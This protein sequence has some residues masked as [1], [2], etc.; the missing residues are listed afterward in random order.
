MGN[1][2]Q[3]AVQPAPP[4]AIALAARAFGDDYPEACNRRR[5]RLACVLLFAATIVYVPWMWRSLNPALPWLAW[6]FAAANTFSMLSWWVTAL[7]AWSREVP[8]PRPAP[9]GAEPTVAVLIP[10]CGEPIPMVLR[11]VTSVLEQD[12]PRD[13][14]L[15]VVSDDGHDP[16]LR[17]ALAG[18][19]VTYHEPPDRWAPGRDGAAK[20]GNLN[21]AMAWLAEAH[22]DVQFI[23]TRDADDDLGTMRFLRLVVGQL[24]ADDRLA[25]VQS[26]KEAEVSPGDPFNNRDS[27]F[28]RGQMLAR[29]AANAVFPCGSGVVWRRSALE[30]IG[31]FPTWN[32]VEDLQSGVE[33]LRR[34]WR[35]LYLPI[36][37]AVGQHS[38]EDVP[39]VYK[40]R[41]TWA[42]DTVRL[43]VWGDLRGLRLRQ[44]L[45]FVELLLFYLHAFTTVV[46]VPAVA[47]TLLGMLPIVDRPLP[48]FAHVVPMAVANELLLLAL[49]QPYNDRRG[50]QRGQFRA[51]WRIRAMWVGM[52]PVFMVACV[53]AV[54]GGPRRKP[55]YKV[56]RKVH[57]V[58]WHWREI[59]PQSAALV[60]IATV[61][62]CALVWRTLPDAAALFGGLYWGGFNVALF[63]TFVTRS[64]H[65]V[66]RVVPAVAVADGRAAS[67]EEPLPVAVPSAVGSSTVGLSTVGLAEIVAAGERAGTAALLQAIR[68]EAGETAAG[69]PAVHARVAPDDV[70]SPSEGVAPVPA[71]GPTDGEHHRA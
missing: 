13:R 57:D 5:I 4:G 35:G 34:G 29:N 70:A 47:C 2:E 24:L 10:T 11:T 15:V 22:P 25:F 27:T 41:G 51:L 26:I 56:T 63:A 53:R 19:P 58:R 48:Y 1:R 30:D 49:A 60:G 32:L 8:P 36:V 38:P 59:L 40:Q 62:V 12:W 45:H 21:A 55:V 54:L 20:A 23:E 14:L 64:W 44:R 6:S 42:I 65:G 71:P 9:V 69:V 52:A 43:L 68:A 28:Y 16:L 66:R 39:N 3:R 67:L 17:D 61:M 33:A 18:Y 31:G 7:N 50:R 37:G 46:Y